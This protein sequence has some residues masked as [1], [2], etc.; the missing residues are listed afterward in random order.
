M[1]KM[2]G[3]EAG[4]I[5]LNDIFG[6]KV[7]RNAV[8]AVVVTLGKSAAGHAVP[9]RPGRSGAA[10]ALQTGYRRNGRKQHISKQIGGGIV[11]AKQSA[12]T[13]SKKLRRLVKSALPR[14]RWRRIIV[15]SLKM[16]EPRLKMIRYWCIKA[17]DKA[18]IITDIKDENVIRSAANIPGIKTTMVGEMNVYDIVNHTSLIVTRDAVNR[19]EEVYS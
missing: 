11:F 6:I 16:D 17:A 9:Q 5:E 2:D 14:K 18:L 10:E 13:S 7:N 8:H 15:L 3:T 12:D 4:N 1:L 19:I